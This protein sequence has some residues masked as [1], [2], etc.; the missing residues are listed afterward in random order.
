MLLSLLS[1]SLRDTGLP[2]TQTQCMVE[3]LGQKMC[4]KKNLLLN[5]LL[6]KDFSMAY[7]ATFAETSEEEIE[8]GVDKAKGKQFA[9]HSHPGI[10]DFCPSSLFSSIDFELSTV[11]LQ[12][13]E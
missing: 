8:T 2:F 11:T 3:K 5:L 9:L 10:R 1:P 12:G 13:S 6:N 4:T 7:M